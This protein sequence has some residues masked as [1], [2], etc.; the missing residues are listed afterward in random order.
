MPGASNA[1]FVKPGHILFGRG[2]ALMATPFDPLKLS[3][4]GDAFPI[5]EGLARQE[6]T[7]YT[8][9]G[10]SE[11]GGARMAFRPPD[12]N[13]RLPLYARRPKA[14]FGR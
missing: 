4:T 11:A 10:A 13:G 7:P 12:R 5:G 14:G 2:T 8:G 6:F 3:V 9:F 1:A